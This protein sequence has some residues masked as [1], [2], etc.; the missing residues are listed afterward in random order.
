MSA[1]DGKAVIITGAGGALGSAFAHD[2][3]HRGAFVTVNDVDEAAAA[4]TVESIRA[5]GGHAEPAVVD[6]TTW[7]GAKDLV[8]RV[9]AEH[10]RL[11]GLVNNAG[12]FAMQDIAD[13]DEA[14]IRR[15]VDVNVYGTLFCGLFAIRQMMEQSHGSI[16]NITSGAH[17]GLSHEFAY[18]PAKG[19]SSSATY[20]WAA[21][22]AQ[23]DIRVNG[24]SP[25]AESK[26]LAAGR[27]YRL[28]QGEATSLTAA[29]S[30][31]S[32]APL[33][34]YLLSDDSAGVS[35]QIFRFDGTLLGIYAHPAV[36]VPVHERENW[37]LEAVRQAFD[38]DFRDRLQPVGLV[39][40][41]TQFHGSAAG[42]WPRAH[43]LPSDGATSRPGALQDPAAPAHAD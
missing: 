25:V 38:T 16:V 20:C 19:A 40:V 3:A 30:P 29:K 5:A 23:T 41:S 22:L 36:A 21:D 33:V 27:S 14:T 18:G 2:A 43:R 9:V 28:S 4:R 7:D 10:G 32:N 26:M 24:V 37:S 1:L 13:Y 12:A 42:A 34:S 6:I 35:G 8:E 39:G 11:D 17:I 15:I 31:E